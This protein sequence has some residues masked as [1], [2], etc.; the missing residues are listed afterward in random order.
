MSASDDQFSGRGGLSEEAIHAWQTSVLAGQGCLDVFIGG[1]LRQVSQGCYCRLTAQHLGG[2]SL[3][4][5]GC[6]IAWKQFVSMSK[7]KY[8]RKINFWKF[9]TYYNNFFL[10]LLIRTHSS[11]GSFLFPVERTWRP[12]S[13]KIT[14]RDSRFIINI[15]LSCVLAL[16]SSIWMYRNKTQVKVL[17][18]TPH[19]CFNSKSYC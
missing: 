15:D 18:I 6:H 3:N 12:T 10:Y 11:C 19:F 9:R 14:G 8:I 13:S 17:S 4:I 2:Y 16:S 1:Q 7:N 5:T